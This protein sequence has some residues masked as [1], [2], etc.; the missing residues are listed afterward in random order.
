MMEIENNF[1]NALSP[2]SKTKLKKK[3]SRT[4]RFEMEE[5]NYGKYDNVAYNVYKP[6]QGS[7]SPQGF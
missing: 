5:V 2:G 3:R 4:E 6:T 7:V 1:P